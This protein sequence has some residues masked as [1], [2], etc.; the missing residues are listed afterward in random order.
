M[1]LSLLAKANVPQDPEIPR[2]VNALTKV[3]GVSGHS[4][5]PPGKDDMVG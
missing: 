4:G 1:F 3:I 5:F 2:L